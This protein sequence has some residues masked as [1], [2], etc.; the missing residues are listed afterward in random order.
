MDI[1]EFKSVSSKDSLS[2]SDSAGV[3]QVG[4]G[5]LFLDLADLASSKPAV[6]GGLQ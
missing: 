2:G 4:A 3:V 6:A 1:M 5:L